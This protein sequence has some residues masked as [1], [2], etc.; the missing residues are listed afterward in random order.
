MLRA[1]DAAWG[2]P[3]RMLEAMR[4]GV[5]DLER[6]VSEQS[7][8]SPVWIAALYKLRQSLGRISQLFDVDRAIVSTRVREFGSEL[9]QRLFEYYRDSMHADSYFVRGVV[10][11]TDRDG[12][13]DTRFRDREFPL[14]VEQ[15]GAELLLN[16]PSAFQLFVSNHEWQAAHEIV[17]LRK[18]AFTTPGLKGWRAVT[19]ANVTPSEAE[20]RFDEAADAFNVDAMPA[21]PEEMAQRGGHW[22]GANQQLWA[23]YC[24]ARA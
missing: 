18:E 5:A 4:A 1:S 22:S 15:P 16:I 7:P 19:L 10:I 12:L 17:I 8:S 14:G 3:E 13:W 11:V 2:Q 20:M 24:R 9:A 23:K 6:V 21:S